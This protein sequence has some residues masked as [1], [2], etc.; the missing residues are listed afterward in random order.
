[1][2]VGKRA[3]IWYDGEQ[4]ITTIVYSEK[5]EEALRAR[6]KASPGS[7]VRHVTPVFNV[8]EANARLA[9]GARP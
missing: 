9:P 8:E 1:M 4:L 3:V 2:L 6:V 7:E 5:G